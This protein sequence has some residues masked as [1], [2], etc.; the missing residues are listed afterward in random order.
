MEKTR[1]L[2]EAKRL[3]IIRRIR[4]FELRNSKNREERCMFPITTFDDSYLNEYK[5][6]EGNID[7]SIIRKR[8]IDIIYKEL[9]SDKYDLFKINEVCNTYIEKIEDNPLIGIF[10][11]N[12]I[13]NNVIL[14]LNSFLGLL[15][16][17]TYLYRKGNIFVCHI[18]S[19]YYT[20]IL[21]EVY[22]KL[23]KVWTEDTK[24]E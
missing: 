3:G 22:E 11:R 21:T 2:K 1:D 23:N 10:P 13:M 24:G 12:P 18:L 8:L 5:D 19:P 9:T 4:N 15:G 6:K 20:D 14:T 16:C 7:D 17:E